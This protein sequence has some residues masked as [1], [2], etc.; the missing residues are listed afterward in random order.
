MRS[1][2]A[3]PYH[4]AIL[5]CTRRLST[6]EKA[7]SNRRFELELGMGDRLSP[8]WTAKCTRFIQQPRLL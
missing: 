8:L 2:G 4:Y 1:T 5:R 6:E 7:R 3:I